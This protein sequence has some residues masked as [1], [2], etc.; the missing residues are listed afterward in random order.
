MFLLSS[1]CEE[2]EEESVDD[3][4]MSDNS[5]LSTDSRDDTEVSVNNSAPSNEVVT[6]SNFLWGYC[7]E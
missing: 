7:D 5:T 3:S 4:S 6:L 1:S 2:S